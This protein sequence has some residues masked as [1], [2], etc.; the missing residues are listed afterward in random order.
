MKILRRDG[1]ALDDHVV[2]GEVRAEAARLLLE[3]EVVL[4]G[5]GEALQV[6]VLGRPVQLLHILGSLL[7]WFGVG[8]GGRGSWC[9]L[10][11]RE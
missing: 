11:W 5:V 6:A 9:E 4:V 8:F 3:D 1:G 7:W 10:N 2:A